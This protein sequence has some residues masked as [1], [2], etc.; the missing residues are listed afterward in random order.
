MILDYIRQGLNKLGYNTVH[1][2]KDRLTVGKGNELIA[3]TNNELT[4]QVILEVNGV[5]VSIHHHYKDKINI[6][7]FLEY[8][9]K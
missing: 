2:S 1:K 3:L 5:T 6:V 7:E 9:T 8:I 4:I